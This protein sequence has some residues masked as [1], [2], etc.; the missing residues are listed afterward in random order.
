M[1]CGKGVCDK[2]NRFAKKGF[3]AKRMVQAISFGLAPICGHGV[4][5]VMRK[6]L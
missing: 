6:R 2:M 1:P 3:W 5:I 4:L